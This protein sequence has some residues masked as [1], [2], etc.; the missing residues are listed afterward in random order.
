MMI[1]KTYGLI[2]GIF[3]LLLFASGCTKKADNGGKI[4]IEN[5][6][7]P[8][9]ITSFTTTE[10]EICRVEG[11]P[12][13]RLFSTS[14][15]PHCAW[16]KNTYDKVTKEYQDQGKIVAYHWEV[17]TKDDLLTTAKEGEVPGKELEVFKQYNPD[18]SIPTFVFGCKY[19][20][21]GNGYEQQDN[22]AAEEQEFRLVIE[23]LLNQAKNEN[24]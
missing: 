10:E 11:K 2:L 21:I 12:V 19:V 7:I 8:T 18:G 20:R 15:C 23:D 6:F 14:W 13:I 4:T 1:K 9:A 3:I 24:Q 16:I 22:L 17:D 5:K